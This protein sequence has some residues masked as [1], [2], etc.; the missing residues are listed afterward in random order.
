MIPKARLKAV[1]RELCQD[2]ILAELPTG[3]V[4][5]GKLA[6][7][8][9]G[10]TDGDEELAALAAT[11]TDED[12]FAVEGFMSEIAHAIVWRGL[13]ARRENWEPGRRKRGRPRR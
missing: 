8:M 12:L 2:L 4:T 3:S 9:G 10:N 6:S 11:I 13:L 5:A 1:A 7:C